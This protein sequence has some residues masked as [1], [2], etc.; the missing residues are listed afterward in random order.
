MSDHE[1]GGDREGRGDPEAGGTDGAEPAAREP[2]ADLRRME[3]LR[4]RIMDCDRE[5]VDV[6]RRRRDL[7]LEVGALKTSLGFP[8]TD[9]RREAH[10]V[11]RAARL[12]RE[13]GLDEELVRNL[14][15]SIMSAARSQQYAPGDRAKGTRRTE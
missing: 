1:G 3:Q 9:P 2:A 5:L 10:V 7:V 8:V 11:R 4:E 6:L 12:A 14:I 13:A 15:W